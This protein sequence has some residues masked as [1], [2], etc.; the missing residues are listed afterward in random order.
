LQQLL[1][2][3]WN[4]KMATNISYT[5][6]YMCWCLHLWDNSIKMEKKCLKQKFQ[7]KQKHVLYAQYTFCW[8][9][10]DNQAIRILM[11]SSQDSR[12][13]GLIL[14][15]LIMLSYAVH[16]TFCSTVNTF[17]VTNEGRVW[18][19]RMNDPTT[20]DFFMLLLWK[21]LLQFSLGKDRL[22]FSCAL[23]WL[24]FLLWKYCL[25]FSNL[26]VQCKEV[27]Y[28]NFI[29]FLHLY[30]WFCVVFS[31]FKWLCWMVNLL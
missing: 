10:W 25:C 24:Y 7:R 14:S 31:L 28:I 18:Y 1:T 15:S 5:K 12:T 9:I 23:D 2:F 13:I 8:S 27:K 30:F 21:V 4:W 22:C 29:L 19:A 20:N 6:T 26:H 16:K 3:H 17:P 11:L